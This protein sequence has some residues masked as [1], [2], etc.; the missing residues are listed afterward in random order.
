MG[1]LHLQIDLASLSKVDGNV[2]GGCR[3]MPMLIT[4][5][6]TTLKLDKAGYSKYGFL[7]QYLKMLTS[8]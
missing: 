3:I 2:V 1:S 5:T 7:F 6:L 8:L 4:L